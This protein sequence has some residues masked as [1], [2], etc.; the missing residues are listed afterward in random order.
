[1]QNACELGMIM[2]VRNVQIRNVPDR[3]HRV[4]VRRAKQEGRSLQEY[5]LSLVTEHAGRPTMQEWIARVESR[6]GGRVGGQEAVDA[7]HEA[8]REREEQMDRWS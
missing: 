4:L 1:M 2:V 8:R 5:L 3:V 7:I 6:S